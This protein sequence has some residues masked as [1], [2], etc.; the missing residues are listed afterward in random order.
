[1]SVTTGIF[2]VLDNGTQVNYYKLS[3]SCGIEITVLD[4]G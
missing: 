4:L 3:S 1:M 2:G